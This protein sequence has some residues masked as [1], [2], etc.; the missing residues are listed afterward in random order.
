[1]V[2]I[3]K[4]V[5]AVNAIMQMEKSAI[6]PSGENTTDQQAKENETNVPVFEFR[7]VDFAYPARPDKPVLTNLNISV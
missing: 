6:F 7:N 1:L 2:D 3:S 5:A 4:G